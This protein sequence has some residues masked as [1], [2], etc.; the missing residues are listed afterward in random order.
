M[1]TN[2]LYTHSMVWKPTPSIPIVYTTMTLK[3]KMIFFDVNQAETSQLQ[4]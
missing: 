3:I 4:F 2:T 1:E